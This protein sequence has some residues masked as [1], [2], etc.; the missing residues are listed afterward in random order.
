MTIIDSWNLEDDL[1]VAVD[2]A[3]DG[4]KHLLVGLGVDVDAVAVARVERRRQEHLE[5]AD[6]AM[7]HVGKCQRH[8]KLQS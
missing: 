8:R 3:I 5:D 6:V 4:F 7:D 2:D 1:V